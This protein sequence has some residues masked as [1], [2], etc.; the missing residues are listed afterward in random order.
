MRLAPRLLSPS[1]RDH[2]GEKLLSDENALLALDLLQRTSLEKLDE[3]IGMLKEQ[4]PARAVR[5]ALIELLVTARL[6]DFA[7]IERALM[8]HFGDRGE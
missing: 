3:A 7:S 4:R 5:A 2:A 8:K 1:P 6:S